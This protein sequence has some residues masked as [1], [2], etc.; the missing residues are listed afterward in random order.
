[1]TFYYKFTKL[2]FVYVQVE[3]SNKTIA[4][5]GVSKYRSDFIRIDPKQV[6]VTFDDYTHQR[7]TLKMLKNI[8]E[9]ANYEITESKDGKS[10]V[11]ELPKNNLLE[12]I[13]AIYSDVP[14]IK[15]A[16]IFI[17]SGRSC[18]G[19][20]NTPKFTKWMMEQL[21]TMDVPKELKQKDAFIPICIFKETKN[22]STEKQEVKLL[23]HS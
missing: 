3:A 17:I 19:V 2:P 22:T 9:V 23:E 6:A 18:F 7:F 14:G 16:N 20:K 10:Y 1:M 5:A 13:K 12:A 4:D 8:A 15:D 21:G 11:V